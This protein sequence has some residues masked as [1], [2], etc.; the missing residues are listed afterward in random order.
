MPFRCGLSFDIRTCSANVFTAAIELTR[1]D[2]S[3]WVATAA[4]DPQL[5]GAVPV[6]ALAMLLAGED[7]DHNVVVPPT[8][9][10]HDMLFT[11]DV[12]NMEELS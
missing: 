3:T 10:T 2:P 11:S 5:V 7:P 4:T 12:K 6:R 9:V 8:L 1:E